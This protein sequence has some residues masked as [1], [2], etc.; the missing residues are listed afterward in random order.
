MER[1]AEGVVRKFQ[2]FKVSE[3][4]GFKVQSFKVHNSLLPEIEKPPHVRRLF[5][6]SRRASIA[7]ARTLQP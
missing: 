1:R 2:S 5:A 6:F 4:Q 3:F 7:A